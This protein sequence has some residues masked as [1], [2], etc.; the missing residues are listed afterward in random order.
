MPEP[1][2]SHLSPPS[3]EH[4]VEALRRPETYPVPTGPVHAVETHMS[5]VFLTD[6]LV[7]K[8]KKPVRRPYLD[9]STLGLRARNCDA[10]IRLNR[11]LADDVY[12]GRAGL[13]Q[14]ADRSL[15]VDGPGT[16]VEWLVCM[17]RLPEQRTLAHLLPKGEP[18][19]RDL[20][21]VAD[22]LAEFYARQP[23]ADLDAA[24]YL[25]DLEADL[26]QSLRTLRDPASRLSDQLVRAACDPPLRCL[27]GMPDLFR[28]RVQQGHVVEGHGDLRPEHVYVLEPPAVLDCLEF[29]PQLRT[30]DAADDLAFLSM[31]CERLR[32]AFV[33]PLLF[34]SYGRHSGDSVPPRLVTFYK[35]YRAVQRAR[36]AA[37]RLQDGDRDAFARFHSRATEYLRLARRHAAM[38]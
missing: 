9:F 23:P 1:S 30:L 24:S 19:P 8:L 26:Q 6:Q 3:L 16:P 29:N 5:W 25:A 11:R 14:Q 17:R 35:C 4:K 7:Y 21:P 34:G 31:E 38:L 28:R 12:L 18:C 22:R 36:L 33:G 32:A 37:W 20:A 13:C 27:A 10:E 15:R 2:P